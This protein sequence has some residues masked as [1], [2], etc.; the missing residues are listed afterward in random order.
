MCGIMVIKF[1]SKEIY[2]DLI[3]NVKGKQGSIYF[4][5]AGV[6]LKVDGT[7]T[8]GKTIQEWLK[9]YLKT[10]NT[11]FREP[12][13]TQAF[14]DFFLSEKN[15]ENLLE[16]K[17]FHYTKTPAF[18]IANFDSYC[19]KIEFEPYCLYADYL[20]FGYEMI[21][22]NI[23]IEDIWLKKIW[24]IAG[25]SARFPLKTQVKRDVIYN[26]RPNSDFKKGKPSV[27]KNEKDFLIA[28]EGTIRKYKGNSRAREWKNNFC[29]N[30]KNHFGKEI[31]F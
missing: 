11:Y 25:T 17:S 22:G 1:N 14:P 12:A 4:N 20:V 26:I 31:S 24:E 29:E 18:D 16:I 23:S 30:Y 15:D 9:E 21:N 10:K 3:L 13:N 8:V 2:R 19:A 27:F 5:L 6:C 28:V 7:D